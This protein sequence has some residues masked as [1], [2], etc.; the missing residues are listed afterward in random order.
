MVPFGREGRIRKGVKKP[1]CSLAGRGSRQ[2]ARIFKLE[3][4]LESSGAL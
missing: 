1:E 4:A 2:E 3:L